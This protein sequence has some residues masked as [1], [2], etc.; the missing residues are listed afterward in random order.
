MV[1]RWLEVL[2]IWMLK[3]K[4]AVSEILW[5]E[6]ILRGFGQCNHSDMFADISQPHW[7]LQRERKLCGNVDGFTRE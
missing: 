1:E 4:D 2:W 7:E 6:D 3:F 5:E